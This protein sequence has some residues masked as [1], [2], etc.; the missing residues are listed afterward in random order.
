MYINHK[1]MRYIT[2]I[3]KLGFNDYRIYGAA[4]TIRYMYYNLQSSIKA[5]NEL[6]RKDEQAYIEGRLYN[7]R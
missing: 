7:G 3:E 5:Y 6:A 1:P 2:M 4:G